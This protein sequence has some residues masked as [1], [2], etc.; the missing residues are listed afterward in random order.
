MFYRSKFSLLCAL[1]SSL[2]MS[3]CGGGGSSLKTVPVT[4]K[5]TFK[6]AP[7]A[8]A[9]VSFL[10]QDQAGRP[11]GGK[12]NE[13]GEYTLTTLETGTKMAQGALVG[14]YKVAIVKSN[15]PS[16]DAMNQPD[17]TAAQSEQYLEKMRS[18]SA[19]DQQ[20][21]GTAGQGGFNTANSS[22]IPMRYMSAEE[23]GLT[24]SVKAGGPPINFELT[25]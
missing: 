22:E 19:E 4:G 17:M 18:G 8:G 6:G 1:A 25:E 15:Q 12:T 16:A 10:N 21:M 7:L 13:Q 3:G 24:A 20:K 14:E 2:F 9:T 23:S 11:A 5:V